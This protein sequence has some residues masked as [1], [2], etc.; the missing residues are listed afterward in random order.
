MP[1]RSVRWRSSAAG[2]LLDNSLRHTP[3]GGQVRLTGKGGDAVELTVAD[4][5]GGIP[6]E[7]LPYVFE[8]FYRVDRARDRAHGGSGIGLAI[9]KALVEAHGG[10][11]KATSGGPGRG[12]TFTITLLV[13]CRRN[14]E[15]SDPQ[16][17]ELPQLNAAKPS[18]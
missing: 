5:G 9:V 4:S 8:R 14:P 12:A 10:T 15:C 16:R 6:T 18:A 17:A 13:A 7:H 11:V 2:S 3:A 1:P